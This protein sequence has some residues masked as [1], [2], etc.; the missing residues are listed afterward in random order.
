MTVGGSILYDCPAGSYSG[1]TV[2]G[3][4]LIG[5]EIGV[6]Y[7]PSWRVHFVELELA[8]GVGQ[9]QC[10]DGERSGI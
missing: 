4:L 10:D 9:K 2:A 1:C 3:S 6:P 7:Y 5:G 8:I